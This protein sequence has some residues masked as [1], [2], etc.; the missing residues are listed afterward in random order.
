MTSLRI[1]APAMLLIAS[2][3]AMASATE[4]LSVP[5][6]KTTYSVQL[7]YEMWR[8]GNAY[9]ATEYQ[10]S[11]YQDAVLMAD[12]FEIALE[13]GEICELMNCSFDWIITDVRIVTKHE[14]YQPAQYNYFQRDL[15]YR[16]LP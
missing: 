16:S 3:P 14:Y 5:F 1:L 2:L 11:N 9:W 4:P 15:L 10:T 8:N 12:L 13:A 7:R 6:V